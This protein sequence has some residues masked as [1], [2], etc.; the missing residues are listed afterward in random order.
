MVNVESSIVN[1]EPACRPAG[2]QLMAVYC[3]VFSAF[4][5]TIFLNAKGAK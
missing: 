3:A 1:R 4:L 2:R 5:S